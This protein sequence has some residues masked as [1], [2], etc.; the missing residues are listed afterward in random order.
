MQ[1]K[2]KNINNSK[3]FKGMKGKLLI[4]IIPLVIVTIAS[5]VLT[6]YF[7]S[8]SII[9]DYANELVQSQTISNA[10]EVETWSQTILSSLNQVKNTL[11]NVEMTDQELMDY[12]ATNMN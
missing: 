6:M 4:I 9:V 8:K 10:N 2:K 1:I 3:G 12:L 11:D 7:K 5:L